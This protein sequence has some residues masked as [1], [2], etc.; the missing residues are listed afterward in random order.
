MNIP[1]GTT[2]GGINHLVK[3]AIDKMPQKT[4]AQKKKKS[5]FNA[6]YAHLDSVRIAWRNDVMHPKE[7]YSEEE[8]RVLGHVKSFMRHLAGV[9][10]EGKV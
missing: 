5:N 7:S 1:D 6:A 2:W 9:I 10:K 4:K 8:A 3:P